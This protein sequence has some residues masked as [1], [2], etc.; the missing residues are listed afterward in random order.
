MRPLFH[1]LR[2]AGPG[3]VAAIV[4][5]TLVAALW[6]P[7]APTAISVTGAAAPSLEAQESPVAAQESALG[8]QESPV[9]AIR[10]RNEAV[11]EILRTVEGDSVVGETRERLKDEI[12]SL[13]DFPELSSRALGRYWDD[14]T[15][16]E[17]EDF[18]S[19]FREL[20]RNSSVR[21]LGVHEADS[22]TYARPE[23]EGDEATVTTTAHKSGSEVEIVYHLER[24]D[25]EWKAWD[26]VIDGS[27]TMRTYRDSFYREIAATSFQAMLNRLKERLA[28]EN[29]S[30][31]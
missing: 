31:T 2:R 8:A 21:K 16:E 7:T 6:A 28:E 26:V 13:I 27:S 17:R 20:V 30:A 22:V 15:E 5:A 12:N 29:V 11:R 4:A 24:T 3:R 14:R 9:D 19:V 18:I 25:G 23:V 10:S 1:T